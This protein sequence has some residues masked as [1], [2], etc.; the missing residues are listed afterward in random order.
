LLRPLALLALAAL[1]A[2]TPAP[3][4]G[5]AYFNQRNHPEIDWRVAETEHFRIIYPAHLAGIESEAAAVAEASYDSLSVAFGGV[6]FDEPLRIYLTDEDEIANGVAF[7][8]GG[9]VT[10]IWVHVNEFAEIWTGEPKW[11]RIVIAH[12]LAHLFHYRATRSGLG[13]LQNLVADP[14]PSFWAEGVA[15]YMT[16]RWD[17]QRGDRW[18]RTAV[19]EDRINY[20]DRAG[21]NNGRLKY[22][23]GNS[24]ARYL[25]WR[26]GDSTIVRL[27][28][29]RR[30]TVPGVLPPVHDFYSAFRATTG[31]TY[32]SFQDEW[33]R[34]V[35]VYYNTIAGRMERVDSLA[36]KP[37]AIPGQ[38]IY[39]V[40]YSRDT[41]RMAALVLTSLVRPVRRLFV[42]D[43]PSRHRNRP[44]VNLRVLAEGSIGG[45]FAWSADGSRIAYSREIR[46][47][48]GSLQNDVY[49]VDVATGRTRRL[50][51]D[52]RA[53]SPTFSPDGRRLAFVGVDRGTANVFL[54]DIESG[55]ETPL[56]RFSG[57]VQITS[58]RWA[59]TGDRIA[60]A[61][62][63]ADGRR[64]LLVVDAVTGAVDTL[65]TGDGLE[66]ARHDSRLPVWR[67]DGRAIA[68]T[69]LRD[70]VPNVFVVG[71]G[72]EPAA[73]GAPAGGVGPVGHGS[74]GDSI[75]TVT[76]AAH[77]PAGPAPET[78]VTYVFAGAAAHAWLPADSTHPDGRLVLVSSET[79][80]RDRAYVVDAARRP[81]VAVDSGGARGWVPP[82]Y[83]A[84]T[85]ERPLAEVPFQIAADTT[86]VRRRTGY[87]SL[88]NLTHAITLPL[89]YAD[90]GE[91]G[92]FGDGDDDIGVFANSIWLEPLNK[93]RLF[94]LGGVSFT[95]FVDRS[96]LL[97]E[98]VNNT[99]APSIATTIY[100]FPSPSS[101]YGDNLLVEN[102]TG[103]DIS[104]TLPLDITDRP[105]RQHLVGMRL[106]Y[107]YAEPYDLSDPNFEAD[108]GPLPP[109]EDGFRAD[110]QVGYAYK[111]Q[112]P[113]RWNVIYP[114][115]G[116]GLRA[117][118]TAGA[119]VLWSEN[120]FVRPDLDAYWVSPQLGIGRF[121]V[122]GRATAVFG[123][124]L[125]QDYVGLAR[126]DDFDFQ[127]PVLGAVT[128]DDAER[129]R[130][131]RR[132]AVGTRVLFG[133]IEYRMPPV[134]NLH[135][136]LFGIV[137]LGRVSPAMFLDAGM[138]WTGS[139]IDGA[140]RRA[141][142]G[143]ELKNV[144]SLGGF[145]LLHSVGVALPWG[146]IGATDL[147]WDD[148]D[149]YYRIQAAVPF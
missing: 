20:N 87:N 38:Y 45:P 24:Q 124:T 122:R 42:M 147:V 23:V 120:R 65:A 144:L 98:Y 89:P 54:V 52:R 62:F 43:T 140:I 92:R 8:F 69:S 4:Q 118:V 12:E 119:P 39:D 71:V 101:F 143:L 1:V 28:R 77:V 104:A 127:L 37:L 53:A 138:V 61:S 103:G 137:G 78:R 135:T 67:P 41:S 15:Q 112:R 117:R 59:P 60:M 49:V 13:L 100:R 50:T 141:G 129:V 5:F 26:F 2:A 134:I 106:R 95:R 125:A 27:L 46:G 80:R 146:R 56:T 115:D 148:V 36:R 111:F 136:N 107:A 51:R 58:A 10:N 75:A 55:V 22:A 90:P 133:T 102:L 74:L 131:V 63:T 116:V 73:T 109:P 35:N 126:H 93:H 91:N 149:L 121:Y 81:T 139:D 145:E 9:G 70:D 31:M 110:A 32:T 11:L 44:R 105:F 14:M 30:P 130:G 88:R 40:Q 6:T 96:F 76:A 18:L 72:D 82:A 113:Y 123:R 34:H 94:I 132:Y 128:L 25:A 97:L 47:R 19:F 48:H 3:A 79:K 83:A 17:A 85:L 64:D 84:W 114:L 142:A 86:L 29:H 68:Y 7:E 57:D 21:A 66:S 108:G 99:L 33:R 16:E